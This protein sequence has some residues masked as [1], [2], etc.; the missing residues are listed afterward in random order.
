MLTRLDRVDEALDLQRAVLENVVATREQWAALWALHF[1]AWALARMIAASGAAAGAAGPRSLTSAAEIALIAGGTRTLRAVLGVDLTRLGAF[2]DIA[3]EA[4]EVASEVLGRDAFD[5]TER[6]GAALQPEAQEVHRLAL[7]A[8]TIDTARVLTRERRAGGREWYALTGAER[9]ISRLV[10]A[11][12]T[13]SVIAA[14]RG[15]SRRTVDAQM[16]AILQKLRI[17]SR[18]RIADFIPGE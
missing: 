10:A 11:G 13:N 18:T 12:Y 16:S 9:E 4:V 6:Y 3:E 7:G 17:T 8:A 1:R 2:C 5:A 14:R 15:T